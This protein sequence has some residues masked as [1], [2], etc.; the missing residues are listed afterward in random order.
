MMMCLYRQANPKT[1]L[2]AGILFLLAV[3][4]TSQAGLYED[5]LDFSLTVAS[6]KTQWTYNNVERETRVDS[7]TAVI[8]QSLSDTIRGSLRLSYLDISQSSNPQPVGLSGSGNGLGIGIQNL[9]VNDPSWRLYLRFGYDYSSTDNSQ[10]DQK[11]ETTWYTTS[12]GVDAILAPRNSVSFLLG[13][14]VASVDGEE[15]LSGPINQVNEFEEDESVAY[16]GGLSIKTDKRG[17]I[18]LRWYGGTSE[19]FVMNFSRHF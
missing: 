16:Y 19:G 15:Q 17:R 13:A 12:A 4:G 2:F 9:L 6:S 5:D 11:I 10:G 18:G 3:P 7:I 8:S 1:R 14:G